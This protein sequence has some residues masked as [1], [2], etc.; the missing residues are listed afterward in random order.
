[1]AKTSVKKSA[2]AAKKNSASKK[3]APAKKAATSKVT[4]KKDDAKKTAPKKVAPKK[5]APKKVSGPKKRAAASSKEKTSKKAPIE[6]VN[7]VARKAK[8]A[9]PPTKKTAGKVKK[10]AADKGVRSKV[11][12]Q[13]DAE[14]LLDAI[15]EGLQDMK[16]VNIVSINLSNIE[17]AV[18]NYFV[19]CEGEATT[20]IKGIA[21]NV[22]DKVFKTVG[23]KPWHIEGMENLEWVVVDYV[24]VVLHIFRRES[25]LFYQ[26][27]D[28]WTDG[29]RTEH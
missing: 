16:A 23:E 11:T 10:T 6:V 19:I 5:A 20:H 24:N 26:L 21:N 18:A 7:E 2:P 27:E 17:D 28:L 12:Q 8:P 3:S 22:E 14:R 29:V 13:G 4:A 15:I 9:L 1:L 25:R